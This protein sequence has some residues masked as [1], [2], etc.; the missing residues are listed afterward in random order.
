M[1]P[2]RV[3]R[4]EKV[5]RVKAQGQEGAECT[6]GRSRRWM[7]IEEKQLGKEWR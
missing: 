3:F 5:A 7:W 6:P 1:K 4:A 2:Y